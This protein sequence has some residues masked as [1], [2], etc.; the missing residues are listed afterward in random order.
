MVKLRAADRAV[1]VGVQTREH[2]RANLFAASGHRGTH[3]FGSHRA[4]AVGVTTGEALGGRGKEF[5]LADAAVPVR[6]PPARSGDTVLGKRRAS[7]GQGGH[8]ADDEGFHGLLHRGC[9]PC[10]EGQTAAEPDSVAM[11]DSKARRA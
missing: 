4:V 1:A 11:A 2:L 9:N 8:A 3:L 7:N 6:I 5:R 10:L